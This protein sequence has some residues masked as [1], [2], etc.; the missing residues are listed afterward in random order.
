MPQITRRR[1]PAA[2]SL[3]PRSCRSHADAASPTLLPIACWYFSRTHVVP[4]D[5]FADAAILMSALWRRWPSAHPPTPWTC[6]LARQRRESDHLL[7]PWSLWL[8]ANAA[9]VPFACQH[10]RHVPAWSSEAV[11]LLVCPQTPWTCWSL[12]DALFLETTRL[13]P[14]TPLTSCLPA[15]AADLKT[16]R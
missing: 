1:G 3:T 9:D 6:L 14:L 16:A 7:T 8:L 12:A 4:S 2:G 10:R 15:D 5:C 11:G 13:T